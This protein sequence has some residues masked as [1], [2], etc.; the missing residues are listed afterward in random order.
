MIS[1]EVQEVFLNCTEQGFD[2]IDEMLKAYVLIGLHNIDL[3]LEQYRWKSE[4][5]Q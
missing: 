5:K 2:T 1:K 4:L 3:N